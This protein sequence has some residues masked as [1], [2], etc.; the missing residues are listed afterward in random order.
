ML[1]ALLAATVVVAL[2][3]VADAASTIDFPNTERIP[4]DDPVEV[5]VNISK[6]LFTADGAQAVVLARKDK[7]PDSLGASAVAAEFGGPI[8]YT[9]S[10]SL[11]TATRNEI[12][13]VLSP[14]DNVYIMGGEDA[15]S[16]DV[17]QAIDAR[18]YRT[19]RLAGLTRVETAAEAAF[20][21]G[22][23]PGRTAII[24]RAFDDPGAVE[25][26]QGWVDSVSCG[27]YAAFRKMPILLTD[28]NRNPD[29]IP[30]ATRSMLQRLGIQEVFVCGGP[31]AVPQAHLDQMA[32]MGIKVNR[33]AGETRIETAVAVA[34]D[35]WDYDRTDGKAFILANGWG[36]NYAYGLAASQLSRREAAP[37]LLVNSDEP[38]QCTGTQQSRATICY[39]A[40]HNPSISALIVIGDT[41]L[42][43]DQVFAAAAEAGGLEEDDTPPSKPGGVTAT[44]KPEDDGTNIVVNWNASQDDNG[45][46]ITYTVYYR[47]EAADGPISRSNASK[48]TT[49]KT[50]V[51]LTGL[52]EGATYDVFVDATD[53]FGN[54]SARSPIATAGPL[55]DEVPAAPGAAPTASNATNGVRLEWTKANEADVSGYRIQ[56]AT[57]AAPIEP[58]SSAFLS[59]STVKDVAGKNTV[60]TVDT[61]AADGTRYCYRYRVLDNSDPKNESGASPVTDWTY[62]QAN[63]DTTPP[64][65]APSIYATNI[66]QLR[67]L[68]GAS[69]NSRMRQGS[70]LRVDTIVPAGAFAAGEKGTI[71]IYD[72]EA[73]LGVSDE[74]TATGAEQI[75]T[76]TTSIGS[77]TGELTVVARMRD[78]TGNESNSSTAWLLD[79]SP[80]YFQTPQI[81]S[82]ALIGTDPDA[83]LDAR[84]PQADGIDPTPP[85]R[86]GN[87]EPMSQFLRLYR[88]EVQDFSV[89]LNPNDIS[90]GTYTINPSAVSTQYTI[91][92]DALHRLSV[93]VE[94]A[95]P[96]CVGADPVTGAARRSGD[97]NSVTYALDQGGFGLLA[98]SPAGEDPY[99]F[100]SGSN[101][102]V[103]VVFAKA[104]TAG[105]TVAIE[106]VNGNTIAGPIDNDGDDGD[107][108]ATDQITF[109]VAATSLPAGTYRMI[110][111]ASPL[112]GEGASISTT[113]DFIVGFVHRVHASR[114]VGEDGTSRPTS[115]TITFVAEEGAPAGTYRV[116][117]DSNCSTPAGA[118]FPKTDG[119]ATTRDNQPEV[120]PL[121]QIFWTY[122]SNS[123]P[124]QTFCQADGVMPAAPT[125][126]DAN[127]LGLR[128]NPAVDTFKVAATGAVTFA[129]QTLLY[130][131]GGAGSSYRTGPAVAIQP[132]GD[133]GAIPNAN[134]RSGD[135]VW[136]YVRNVSGNESAPLQ[137]GTVRGLSR[138]RA[139]NAGTVGTLEAGD[140]LELEFDNATLDNSLQPPGGGAGGVRITVG[141]EG[142]DEVVNPK[143]GPGTGSSASM[144]GDTLFIVFDTAATVGGALVP[145]AVL[146]P[147]EV[148]GGLDDNRWQG[149][150][151]LI[152]TTNGHAVILPPVESPRATGTF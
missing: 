33:I 60:S 80:Q 78:T 141:P 45:G 88:N 147:T 114:A 108:A 56:R 123:S 145:Q 4:G 8:L 117:S 119:N 38:T 126:G 133:A 10:T 76:T 28:K 135:G 61:S 130:R 81:E 131:P 9:T 52:T 122:Q 55:E 6:R 24:A 30:E 58:C 1:A 118:A 112:D 82:V 70:N 143:F 106:D 29:D 50:T 134:V 110:I 83:H 92:V 104:A 5:A 69:G 77:R 40:Q 49:T 85:I 136:Y 152:D 129:G 31:V 151:W 132:N 2:P 105:S 101:V 25:N 16:E 19:P 84:I 62:D 44:D 148:D 120:P 43:N 144:V 75:V 12:D 54:R 137:D 32:Q 111:N 146:P 7:F 103:Q 46:S 89:C 63:A 113:K 73:L 93:S 14:G 139:N 107:S 26:T 115:N 20:A 140:S 142:E 67:G 68:N 102:P 37:I 138:I 34:T 116:F 124:S 21:V 74:F 47:N 87:L 65:G 48:K 18:G 121:T 150:D 91:A 128:P 95:A 96:G 149:I 86:I 64:A 66:D 15:I 36:T 72:D 71:A 11:D 59:W 90:G 41:E 109:N 3:R 27:G 97:S 35:L 125:G 99:G 127:V 17:E 94:P 13:R 42:I 53:Q 98:Q 51:T 22:A 100:R 39:L 57:P 23:G 79:V